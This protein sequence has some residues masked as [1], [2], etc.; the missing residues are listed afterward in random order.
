MISVVGINY[1]NSFCENFRVATTLDPGSSKTNGNE[2]SLKGITA[3][4]KTAR[5]NQLDAVSKKRRFDKSGHILD[6]HQP[7]QR[8]DPRS[9]SRFSILEPRLSTSGPS[10]KT[11]PTFN[12]CPTQKGVPSSTKYTSII[13]VVNVGLETIT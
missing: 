2:V 8:G 7:T 9:K 11:G 4:S 1:M 12:S 3:D 6:G 5:P 10:H 13:L